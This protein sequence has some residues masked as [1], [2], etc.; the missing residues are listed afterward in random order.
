MSMSGT[1]VHT[2]NDDPAAPFVPTHVD[3][4]G[5]A[6]PTLQIIIGAT[7]PG[8]VGAEVAH[9]VHRIAAGH[10]GF[11]VDLVDLAEIDLPLL[12]EPV[13]AKMGRY[14]HAHS[15]RWSERV[16]RA[17]AF[18]FVM[19]EYNHGYSAALKNAVDY[20]FHEWSDKPAG[21]VSYGSNV[22]AGARAAESFGAVLVAVK[23][24]VLHESVNI[25]FVHRHLDAGAF[26]STDAFDAAAVA[27]LDELSRVQI[28]SHALRATRYGGSR[29]RQEP[30][31]AHA[32][33]TSSTG[34]TD[35]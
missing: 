4:E 12:D 16:Q 25:P 1:G 30:V 8:R 24:L 11:D 27:M 7:R 35:R 13:G 15:R 33:P 18:V 31:P 23:A 22:G 5:A 6:R 9:W 26:R 19:P 34:G 14:E 3:G 32:G 10:G 28:A 21:M 2:R 29:P 20:L 17:D